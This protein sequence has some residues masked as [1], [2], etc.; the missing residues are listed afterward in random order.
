MSTVTAATTEK[1][2][3]SPRAFLD[4][5]GMPRLVIGVFFFAMLVTGTA[6]ELSL[7]LTISDILKRIGMNGVLVLAMV[8]S[9][10]AGI[11][12]N[13]ALPVGIICGLLGMV[14]AIELGTTGMGFILAAMIIGAATATLL[15]YG[16]GKL[17]NTIKGSEMA[18]ATYTGFAVVALMCIVWLT[19]PFKSPAMKWFMGDGLRETLQL[20]NVGANGIFN[21]FLMFSIGKVEV[22]T[23]LLLVLGLFSLLVWL[24]LRTKTGLAM[25]TVGMNAQFAHAS[26]LNINRNR[27]IG[28]ILTTVL[29][30]LGIIVYAQSYGFVQLYNA[31]LMMAFPAVAAILIG[32]ATPKSARVAHVFIGTLLFQGLLATAMPV[33]NEIFAGT[34]LS[35]MIRMVV[36]NGIIL[37]ALSQSKGGERA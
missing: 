25:T 33:A 29:G 34:D 20:E 21:N 10:Q 6:L 11:G 35:E 31:P 37:Y 2:T 23:G 3:V 1:R 14:C 15:G 19:I 18:I 12:P 32:G 13:F 7:P 5:I 8:P 30:A 9:I 4:K 17:L 16:Y 36:Q 26:G 27:L 22:P 24:F 28:N